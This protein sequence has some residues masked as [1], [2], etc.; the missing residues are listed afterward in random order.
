LT[1]TGVV[2]GACLLGSSLPTATHFFAQQ[3]AQDRLGAIVKNLA[4]IDMAA[5]QWSREQPGAGVPTRENLDGAGGA[6]QR[7]QW[8]LGP[9]SGRYAVTGS[10]GTAAGP[11]HTVASSTTFDGGTK[12][13]MNRLQWQET[14]TAD[15]VSCGL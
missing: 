15:P 11:K 8:P 6:I 2:I 7:V 12:G 1:I 3:R 10:T 9:V 14:C 5:A 4:G 13:P